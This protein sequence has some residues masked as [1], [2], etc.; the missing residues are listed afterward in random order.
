MKE[1]CTDMVGLLDALGLERAVFCGHDW[2]GAVVW[3]MPRFYPDRV[4]GVIG[5]NTPANHPDHPGSRN[6]HIVS[7]DRYYV[8]T[9]QPPGV[10]DAI[11]SADVQL[12][13]EIFLRRGGFWDAEAFAR[14]PEDS[15]ERRVDLLAMFKRGTVSGD[16][17][18][19]QEELA[20]FVETFEVTGFTGGLNWYRGAFQNSDTDAVT[21]WD[22][23]VPCLYVG[24]E[25][26]VILPP[27]SA[28]HIGNF[29][30]DFERYTVADCGH[31]TQQEKPDE[32][33]RVAMDWLKSK[34]GA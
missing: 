32:F 16:L 6:P 27:S 13:F 34:F 17:I 33:N 26:D 31:W 11:L 24:A 15:L 30:E 8:Q 14:L 22:I 23:D 18:L 2:G 4:A 10:A 20:Y 7:S 3:M 25:N 9:F 21:H 12:S 28:D 19:S 5:V 1:L 29:V